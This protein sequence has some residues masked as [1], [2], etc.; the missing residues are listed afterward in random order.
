MK[1]PV[2]PPLPV[3]VS[4]VPVVRVLEKGVKAAPLRSF[5]PAVTWKA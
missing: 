4:V 2:K 1:V 5:R 3:G